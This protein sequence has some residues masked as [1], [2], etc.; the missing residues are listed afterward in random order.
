MLRCQF[1]CHVSKTLFLIK[2]ALK[3]CYFCQKIQNFRPLGAPLPDPLPPAVGVFAPRPPASGILRLRLQTPKQP[4]IANFWLRAWQRARPYGRT[5]HLFVKASSS[6]SNK[7]TWQ[8]VSDT[9]FPLC[10][11][12]KI[13]TDTRQLILLQ[14]FFVIAKRLLKIGIIVEMRSN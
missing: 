3:L 2:I 5:N 7:A 11:L 6:L 12:Y 1:L 8:S 4:P 10:H 9:P 14:V 13:H